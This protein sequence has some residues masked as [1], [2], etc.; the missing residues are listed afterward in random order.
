[1]R[2]THLLVGLRH[3]FAWYPATRVYRRL[4]TQPLLLDRQAP[5]TTHYDILYNRA[6][7]AACGTAA[8]GWASGGPLEQ[9]RFRKAA[10]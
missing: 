9:Q 4:P 2:G 6:L 5:A 8:A 7:Q 3:L 10:V 1:M